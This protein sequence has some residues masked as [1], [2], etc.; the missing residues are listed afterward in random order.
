LI[1]GE[2]RDLPI[3][4]AEAALGT[5]PHAVVFLATLECAEVVKII[6]KRGRLLRD[7]LL[8]ADLN[9]ALI[10]VMNLC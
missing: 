6:L 3:K 7:K 5:L 10:E 4:G 9:E 2:P 1:Y 8:L